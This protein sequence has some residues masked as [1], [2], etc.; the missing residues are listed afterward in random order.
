MHKPENI[1]SFNTGPLHQ[2]KAVSITGALVS[3]VIIIIIFAYAI[4][5]YYSSRRI[6]EIGWLTSLPEWDAHSASGQP[7]R[8]SGRLFGPEDRV[9]PLGQRAAAFW[10]TVASRD[11][12]GGY[13]VKCSA[14]ARSGLILST[15]EGDF[16]IALSK[17]DPDDVGIASDSQ[18]GDYGKP[19]AIDVGSIPSVI[20]KAVPPGIC[21]YGERYLQTYIKQG[22]RAEL[23]GCLRNGEIDRCDGLIAGIL[24]LPDIKS[25]M[26]H[27]LVAATQAFFYPMYAGL[28]LLFLSTIILWKWTSFRLRA[29]I[30]G[31]DGDGR[32]N[33]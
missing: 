19:F 1:Q 11:A 32:W 20:Y 17:A 7:A 15:P 30:S 27:R 18:A 13:D 26:R 10:W 4:A 31:E 2:K 8:F 12:D 21:E 25:D 28:C 14:R 5:A 22:M 29:V 9:T 3:T 23:V 6:K 16:A 24:S 33:K